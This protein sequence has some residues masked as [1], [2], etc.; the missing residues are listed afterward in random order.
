MNRP[1]DWSRRGAVS[2]IR[3]GSLLLG[4]CD[5]NTRHFL[6]G[7][8]VNDWWD[9]D[10]RTLSQDGRKLNRIAKG[11]ACR[12]THPVNG[13]IADKDTVVVFKGTYGFLLCRS[14]LS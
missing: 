4:R 9:L 5:R 1:T 13:E 6:K 11:A 14:L 12:L 2:L 3:C 10:Q 7:F 8:L